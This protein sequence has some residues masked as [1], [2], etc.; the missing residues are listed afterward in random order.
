MLYVMANMS[1]YTGIF[2]QIERAGV[3]SGDSMAVFP[4]F[5][6]TDKQISDIVRY[7]IQIGKALNVIGLMN[8]QYVISDG[9]I[10]CIEVNPRASRTVPIIS[11]VTGIEM[12]KIATKIANGKKLKDFGL[13]S[14]L[15]K[16]PNYFTIKAPVF[17]FDKLKLVE[18]SLG[19]DEV[20][21]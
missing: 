11:K 10:Y 12:V 5:N 8:I 2:E 6:L 14:G 13:S 7:S 1:L 17:S 18:T 21:R 15:L 9:R 3:H 4:P 16:S 19:R 20:N